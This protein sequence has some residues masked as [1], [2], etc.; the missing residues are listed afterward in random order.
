MPDLCTHILAH[1]LAMHNVPEQSQSCVK[2][3]C[4]LRVLSKG[5]QEICKSCDAFTHP[6]VDMRIGLI[7]WRDH[8]CS[9]CEDRRSLQGGLT[10]HINCHVRLHLREHCWQYGYKQLVELF[11]HG[12]KLRFVC[13]VTGRIHA[14]VKVLGFLIIEAKTS[15]GLG[16]SLGALGRGPNALEH[17]SYI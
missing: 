12:S 14:W 5:T 16:F 15:K 6:Y 2:H 3:A 9:R 17:S 1:F 4:S 10:H 13:R 11:G 7:E 8:K